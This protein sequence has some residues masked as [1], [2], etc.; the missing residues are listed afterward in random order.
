[1]KR[2]FLLTILFFAVCFTA[3]AQK[4]SKNIMILLETSL[5]N[6]KIE[7]YNDTPVHRDNFIKLVGEGFYD[8]ILFHRVIEGFMV[9]TGD[10]ESKTATKGARLGSGGPC[11][12]LPAEIVPSHFHKRGAVAAARTGD[13]GNPMRRSSGSQFYIVHGQKTPASTLKQYSRYGFEFSQDQL[14]AYEEIGGA[15][16]LDAQYTV[17][18]EVVEGMDVVDKIATVE[19]DQADRPTTDVKIIKATVIQ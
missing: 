8:G 4:K 12:T 10:P 13:Q 19:K 3:F 2:I 15:P 5:G 9:Q 1:M 11:Y 16:T 7:L 18:G 17:F 14:K 6:I